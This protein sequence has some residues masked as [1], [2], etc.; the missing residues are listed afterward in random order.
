MTTTTMPAA[1]PSLE[2]A[3]TRRRSRGVSGS[4]QQDDVRARPASA[5][6][7]RPPRAPAHR[8]RGRG[9]RVEVVDRDREP[10]PRQA[11]DDAAPDRARADDAAAHQRGRTRLGEAAPPLAPALARWQHERAEAVDGA[12]R[13]RRGRRSSCSRARRSP[14]PR[15]AAPAPSARPVVDRRLAQLRL[16]GDQ[17]GRA[18][19]RA[20][21]ASVARRPTSGVIGRLRRRARARSTRHGQHLDRAAPATSSRRAGRARRGK[22][23]RSRAGSVLSI[24]TVSSC[25]WPT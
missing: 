15:A 4:D 6:A 18:P 11:L 19:T 16:G 1:K 13:S 25:H 5:R 2:P 22:R 8:R 9:A 14:G 23:R 3:A 17:T 20:A 10:R 12:A 24:G 21:S 7:T